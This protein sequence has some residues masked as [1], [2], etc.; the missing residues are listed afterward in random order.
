LSVDKRN[1]SR[2]RFAGPLA[3]GGLV[4]L[5]LLMLVMLYPEK[6]LLKLLSASTVSSPAQQSYLEALVQLR[7]GDVELVTPLVRSYLASGCTE[8]AADV[9]QNQVGPLTADQK[10]IVMQLRYEVLRQQLEWLLHSE[11]GW[12]AARQEYAEQIEQLRRAGA[13]SGELSR[14]LTD[15]RRLGDKLTVQRLEALLGT[16]EQQAS[17]ELTADAALAKGDYRSAAALYFKGMRTAKRLEQRRNLF[18]AAVRALESGN[19][20]QEA[21]ASAEQNLTS[22]LAQDQVVLK[23]L[24][25]LSLAANRPDRAQLY[26]RRALGMS[27]GSENKGSQL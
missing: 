19:L 23:Y 7:K 13:S 20:V 25:K 9:L 4:G 3:I 10:K 2:E 26:V 14:Y 6:T 8:K 5:G 24:I 16:S 27:S 21:L 11:P 12:E 15:A 17:T 18:L 1:S 22:E